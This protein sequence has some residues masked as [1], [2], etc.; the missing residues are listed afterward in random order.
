MAQTR[1][2]VATAQTKVNIAAEKAIHQKFHEYRLLLKI[3]GS[4]GDTNQLD[5]VT[6]VVLARLAQETLASEYHLA[7]AKVNACQEELVVLQNAADEALVFLND[8]NHQVAQISNILDNART[9]IPKDPIPFSSANP[10]FERP[11]NLFSYPMDEDS[12]EEDSEEE[13]SSSQDELDSCDSGRE[14]PTNVAAP[15]PLPH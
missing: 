8:A 4:R 6:A 10:T 9:P 13:S 2:S 7:L 11:D 3:G 5:P 12:E 1:M 15:T 14:T